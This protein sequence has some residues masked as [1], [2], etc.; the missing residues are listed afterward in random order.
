MP[1]PFQWKKFLRKEGEVYQGVI[2]KEGVRSDPANTTALNKIMDC[3]RAHQA[4]VS[5]DS[6]QKI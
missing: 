1:L 5:G 4:T 3:V 6:Y 2:V